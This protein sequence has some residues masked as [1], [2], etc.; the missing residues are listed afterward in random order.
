M[1]ITVQQLLFWA[2]PT[3]FASLT[4]APRPRRLVP[5]PECVETMG[6]TPVLQRSW[7]EGGE[8]CPKLKR[9]PT[10]P[11]RGLYAASTRPLRMCAGEGRHE[12]RWAR[13]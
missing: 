8:G 13:G 4:P 7:A 12:G 9:T 5:A 6:A 10:R 2:L 11:L 1:I 3:L